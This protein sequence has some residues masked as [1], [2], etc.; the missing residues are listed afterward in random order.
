MAEIGQRSTERA[1]ERAATPACNVAL[2]PICTVV[3]AVGTARPDAVDHLL[4]AGRELMMAAKA[5]LDARVEAA[6]RPAR[7][8]KID[9]E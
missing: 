1:R 8:E 4:A 3:V 6:A 2:C 5:I 9:L 7:L